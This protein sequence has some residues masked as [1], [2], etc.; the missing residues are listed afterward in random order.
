MGYSLVQA[1]INQFLQR[2]R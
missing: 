2:G 1:K